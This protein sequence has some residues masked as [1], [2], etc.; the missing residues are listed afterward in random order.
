MK[1]TKM[2]L[3][4]FLMIAFSSLNAHTIFLEKEIYTKPVI[5]KIPKIIHQIWVGKKQIPE[6]YKPFMQTIKNL[7]PDWEYKLWT[8]E[9]VENFPWFNKAAFNKATNPAMKSDIWRIEILYR[10]GGVYL[11]SDMECIRA[12][13]PIHERLRS[14]CGYDSNGKSVIAN[15]VLA[16]EPN[17]LLYKKI[18]L[19]IRKNL[20]KTKHISKIS[21]EEIVSKTG[22]HLITKVINEN[23]NLLNDLNIILSYEYFQPV[24]HQHHGKPRTDQERYDIENSCF[25]IHHNGC[26]WTGSE[27]F[28]SK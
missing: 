9:D 24:Y 5:N 14:Y 4:Y 13:D 15:S 7:H 18:I 26:S 16:S 12:L 23:K 3:F 28:P 21:P 17:N 19:S 11:D 25:A 8:D 6:K 10:Y 1:I 2:I 22:P 20:I 27:F